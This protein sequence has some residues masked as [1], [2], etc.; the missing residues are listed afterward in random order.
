MKIYYYCS[1]THSPTGF[2]KKCFDEVTGEPLLI[3]KENADDAL[4]VNLFTHGGAETA[5]G[6][7]KNGK[8]YFL[9]KNMDKTDETVSQGSKGRVWHINFA[10]SAEENELG[11][12]CSLAYQAYSDYNVFINAVFETLSTGDEKDSFYADI[13][14]FRENSHKAEQNMA[15]SDKVPRI[16]TCPY[17]L[18][19]VKLSEAL[20]ILKNRAIENLYEFVIFSVSKPYFYKNCNIDTD[21]KVY[22]WLSL[23]ENTGTGSVRKDTFYE[24]KEK[25]NSLLV[26]IIVGALVVTGVALFRLGRKGGR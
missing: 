4:I 17:K 6:K 5:F 7:L 19:A 26:P 9:I 22:H 10:V 11:R 12:L 18:D 13:S 20:T 3:D 15:E 24:K 1:Y 23:G 8:Y 2:Q 25:D 14:K 16:C 21:D